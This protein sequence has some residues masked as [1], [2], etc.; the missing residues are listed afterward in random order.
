MLLACPNDGNVQAVEIVGGRIRWK[1]GKQQIGEGFYPL[2]ICT[3]E[4]NTVYVADSAK[5]RVHILSGEDGSVIRS[6]NLKP[7]GIYPSCVRVYEEHIY[8]GHKYESNKYQIK[9]FTKP[10]DW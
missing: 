6:I 8:I 3:D 2:S 7:Y 5:C 9:K 1:V 4:N 10:T